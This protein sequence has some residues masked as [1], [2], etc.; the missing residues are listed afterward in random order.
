MDGTRVGYDTRNLSER[1]RLVRSSLVYIH[2]KYAFLQ[3][4]L[5]KNKF[6]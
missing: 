5:S 3:S 2:H 4:Q 1:V 6:L